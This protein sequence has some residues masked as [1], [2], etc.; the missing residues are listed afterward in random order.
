MVQS[1]SNQKLVLRVPAMI[2]I[3]DEALLQTHQSKTINVSDK[4]Q[5]WQS[6]K[7]KVRYEAIN[8]E[9]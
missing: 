8:K 3:E 4:I 1:G 2:F 7:I 6:L 9:I 5:K